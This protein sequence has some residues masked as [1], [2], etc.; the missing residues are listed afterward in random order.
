MKIIEFPKNIINDG[1]KIKKEFLKEIGMY[2][3]QIINDVDRTEKSL[4]CFK[5]ARY[6][7]NTN[8]KRLRK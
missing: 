6:K 2:S 3:T 5:T 1:G 8:P 7:I 4:K